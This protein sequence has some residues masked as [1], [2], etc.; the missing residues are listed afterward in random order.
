MTLGCRGIFCHYVLRGCRASGNASSIAVFRRAQEDVE[1]LRPADGATLCVTA[2]ADPAVLRPQTAA[3]ARLYSQLTQGAA[4]QQDADATD[5]AMVSAHAPREAPALCIVQAGSRP[6]AACR[7]CEPHDLRT[8]SHLICR[9][10]SSTPFSASRRRT[11]SVP[12]RRA[13]R[14]R[15]EAAGV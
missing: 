13:D 15:L 3:E 11:Q 6:E 14:Q 12:G 4:Q 8:G 7:S 5:T 2:E 9:D 1:R 10:R